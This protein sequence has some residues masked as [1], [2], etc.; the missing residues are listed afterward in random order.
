MWCSIPADNNVYRPYSHSMT[1]L[2]A[3][4]SSN[5]KQ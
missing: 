1:S 2:A 4:V 3:V 5:G